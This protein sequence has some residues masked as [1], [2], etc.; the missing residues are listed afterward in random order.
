MIRVTSDYRWKRLRAIEET[1]WYVQTGPLSWL[2]AGSEVL[3]YRGQWYAVR[4]FL[5]LTEG[6]SG[7]GKWQMYRPDG[8]ASG[9]VLE[10]SD[11]GEEYRVGTYHVGGEL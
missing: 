5:P 8:F 3:L 2:E 9:V 1:P 10:I 6:F 7:P 4:T 11:D